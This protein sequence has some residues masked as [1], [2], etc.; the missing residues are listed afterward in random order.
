L[1]AKNARVFH[2]DGVQ[3]FFLDELVVRLSGYL[4][5]DVGEKS[6]SGVA[7]ATLAAGQEIEWLGFYPGD[8]IGQGYALKFLGWI[9]CSREEVRNSVAVCQH[10]LDGDAVAV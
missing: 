6:V 10:L 5:D 3:K 8:E 9:L 4:L 1:V 2:T 7:V